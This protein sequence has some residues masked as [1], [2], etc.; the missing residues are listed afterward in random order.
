MLLEGDATGLEVVAAGY[1]SQCP[2]LCGEIRSGIDVHKENEN[3]LKLTRLVA[4]KFFFRLIYGGNAYSYANDTEFNHISK[5]PNYWQG[6]IDNFYIKYHGMAEWHRRLVAD[7]QRNGVWTSPTGR[8]YVFYPDS[9]G[10]WPRTTILNYPVQGLGADMLSIIRVSLFN[11][12]RKHPELDKCLLVNS[13]HDSIVIDTP[14]EHIPKLV[15]IINGVFVDFPRNFSRAF[16]SEFNLPLKCKIK[17]GHN[18][19]DMNEYN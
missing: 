19:R 17:T 11:R 13:V 4:K 14:E 15:E 9:R 12:I 8:Q 6:V 18:W 10:E 2:I 16:G 5:R 1:L 3:Y 7:V